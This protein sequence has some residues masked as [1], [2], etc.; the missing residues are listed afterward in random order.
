MFFRCLA[1]YNYSLCLFI[2]SLFLSFCVLSF[3]LIHTHSLSFSLALCLLF[4][5]S[6]LFSPSLPV[7][8]FSSS[9]CSHPLQLLSCGRYPRPP[10]RLS[11]CR[12][13]LAVA[14]LHAHMH[15]NEVIGL[16]GGTYDSKRS[17]TLVMF[18]LFVVFVLGCV[19]LCGVVLCC[20]VLCGVVWCCMVLCCVVLC[21]LFHSMA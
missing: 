12:S 16:L 6:F 21:C 14:D 20:V 13:A 10:F 3:S 17:G 18:C 7:S 15:R 5:L 9:R 4:L 11:V 8:C 1:C 2:S 19:V